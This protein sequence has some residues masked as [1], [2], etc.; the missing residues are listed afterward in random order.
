MKKIV[1]TLLACALISLSVN[2]VFSQTGQ[3]EKRLSDASGGYS[4]AV[5]AGF[6]SQ[7]N[8]EGFGLV[9]G[10]K[11]VVVAVKA[12][13]F[14]T[15]EK[16]AAQA[17][18]ERDGLTLVGKVQDVGA[19][20]KAFRA[21]KQTP[22]G[23]LVV[24][25]FVLF[26]PHGG[27]VLVV[28]FSDTANNE[29]GLRSAFRIAGSVAFARPQE[30]EAGAQWEAF[31]RGKHL[32]YLYTA[33]GYSERKDIYLCPSGKFF[34]RGDASSLSNNGSAAV[35]SDADGS[36]KVSSRGGATLVLQFRGGDVHEY[37]IERRQA[38]NEI[39]LNGKRYF[40]QTFN[41]CPR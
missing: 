28:A 30:S 19:T 21:A 16:F 37:K 23:V 33:S 32:L 40:V 27:G 4:F 10:A 17:N 41:G 9:N 34:F 35:G 36:W 13:D 1:P 5:P 20:G 26:S 12:H 31:F 18:L 24:D 7:Q 14:Q 25:T 3:A 6:V 2:S 38:G 39:G 8:D 22:E 15:F 11:T 29:E